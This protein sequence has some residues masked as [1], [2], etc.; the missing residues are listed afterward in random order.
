VT[1][2]GPNSYEDPAAPSSI[3]VNGFAERFSVPFPELFNVTFTALTVSNASFPWT[4]WVQIPCTFAPGCAE[5]IGVPAGGVCPSWV[6]NCDSATWALPNGTY[7]FHVVGSGPMKVYPTRETVVV[8]GASDVAF[9]QIAN[10]T[11]GPDFFAVQFAET[12][13]PSGAPWSVTFGPPGSGG[14][15]AIDATPTQVVYEPN[16]SY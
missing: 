2:S 10:A 1:T 14:T 3:A 15:T 6:P 5:A 9:L 16:G 4:V 11:G 12:G 7:P 8:N 13:L